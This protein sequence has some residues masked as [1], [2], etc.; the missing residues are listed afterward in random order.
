MTYLLFLC[1]GCL[2]YLYSTISVPGLSVLSTSVSASVFALT[3]AVPKSSAPSLS[4]SLFV[5]FRL[6]APFVSFVAYF[7]YVCCT[8]ASSTSFIACFLYLCLG[9][10]LYCISAFS[11]FFIFILYVSTKSNYVE[12]G[13]NKSIYHN[14]C[15]H[16][17]F[18]IFCLC[19]I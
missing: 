5:V 1:L 8:Y 12:Y 18:Y 11:L 14:V 10:F 7:V 4:A 3:S 15:H 17:T 13:A 9:F 19:T 16:I 2:L 6:S